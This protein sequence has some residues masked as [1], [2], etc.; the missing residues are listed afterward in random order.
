[1][2]VLYL[3]MKPAR[4]HSWNVSPEEA[5]AIQINLRPKV[6]I[7]PYDGPTNLI[8]ATSV[9]FDTN[10]DIMH[11]VVCVVKYPE[12]S[13]KEQFG[14]SQEI[15]FPYVSGLLAF[16]EGG[17]L[18]QLFHK[19]EKE[20]N[21]LMFHAHGQAHPRGFGLASH[22]GVLLD[23]PSIGISTKLLIGHHTELDMEKGSHTPILY[24]DRSIGTA[25]RAKEGVNP[26]Y[27]S[28]G[29][30]TDLTSSL[31]VVKDCI[32]HYRRPEPLR[33][34]QLAVTKQKTGQSIGSIKPSSQTTL[35]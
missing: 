9:A 6:E 2:L 16:R 5:A 33:L 15:R 21:L 19:I 32:T 29:H 10:N 4:V 1:M 35:F 11:A 8:G 34:A 26:I 22:L 3:K 23:I 20:P 28:V 27:V 25:L 31:R 12:M 7:V 30:K 13:L 17:A 24:K 18:I 14:I